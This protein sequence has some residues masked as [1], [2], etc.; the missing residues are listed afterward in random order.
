MIILQRQRISLADSD[1]S[2]EE[3]QNVSHSFTRAAKALVVSE[4]SVVREHSL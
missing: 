4:D 2:V 3:I 1:K